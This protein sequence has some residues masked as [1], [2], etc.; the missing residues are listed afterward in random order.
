MPCIRRCD[1]PFAKPQAVPRAMHSMTLHHA[2]MI[3]RGVRSATT[4]RPPG[5]TERR[6][7]PSCTGGIISGTAPRPGTLPFERR[8]PMHRMIVAFV[9]GA[10]I[11]MAAL[12]LLQGGP[13]AGQ[14]AKVEAG[15]EKEPR[16]I[17][18]Q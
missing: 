7:Q 10:A 3:G 16:K 1:T 18:T 8:F 17:H 4:E 15:K 6:R 2:R 13:L 5:Q 12:L 14:G 11:V 9:A